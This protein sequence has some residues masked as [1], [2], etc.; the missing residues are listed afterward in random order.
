M[1]T[2]HLLLTKSVLWSKVAMYQV[3]LKTYGCFCRFRDAINPSVTINLHCLCF[4]G[5]RWDLL[6]TRDTICESCVK[7]SVRIA[8]CIHHSP[9]KCHSYSTTKDHKHLWQGSELSQHQNKI[10][11]WLVKYCEI[12]RGSLLLA[13]WIIYVKMAMMLFTWFGVRTM[14]SY[15]V[16]V[17]LSNDSNT[18]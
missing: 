16:F 8:Q 15:I 2:I 7:S 1:F 12:L 14:P 10:L 17:L 4:H 18:A 9:L 6:T 11:I 5:S 13:F 3:V